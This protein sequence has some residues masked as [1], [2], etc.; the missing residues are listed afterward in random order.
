MTAIPACA[1]MAPQA[2]EGPCEGQAVA[3]TDLV[4]VRLFRVM[5]VSTNP[6][7]SSDTVTCVPFSC[8]CNVSIAAGACSADGCSLG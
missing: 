6:G 7:I 1:C 3:H 4:F 8:T 2:K 5:A